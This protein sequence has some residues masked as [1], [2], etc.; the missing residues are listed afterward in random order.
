MVGSTPCLIGTKVP[1][2]YN[3]SKEENYLEITID[4]TKGPAFGNTG[5]QCIVISLEHAV[6]IIYC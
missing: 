1:V 5:K 4:V 3:G 2:S 6:R